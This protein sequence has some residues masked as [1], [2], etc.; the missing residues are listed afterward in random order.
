MLYVGKADSLRER[1]RSY[2]VANPGHSRKTRQAV[3]RLRKVEWEETGSSLEAAVREQQLILE[4]RPPCNVQG[5]R[6]ETYVYLK[7]VGKDRGLRLYASDTPGPEGGIVLGPF[8][9]RSRIA[10]AIELL[11]R[12]YPVRQ[13]V[14]SKSGPLC[15]YGQTGRCLSPCQGPAQR[16]AHDRLIL[17]LVAWVAGGT[18]PKSPRRLSGRAG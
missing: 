2:F 5:R 7:A 13:C 1:V 14:S 6:P 9:G 17:D 8:R 12:S 15:L 3:R 16:E 10:Q 11:R 4:H 18:V